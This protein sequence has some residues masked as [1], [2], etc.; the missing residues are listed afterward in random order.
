MSKEPRQIPSAQWIESAVAA[1]WQVLLDSDP[2]QPLREELAASGVAPSTVASLYPIRFED[3]IEG[4]KPLLTAEGLQDLSRL[5][6]VISLDRRAGELFKIMPPS[7]LAVLDEELESDSFFAEK[8]VALGDYVLKLLPAALKQ[9][10]DLM[11]RA[12]VTKLWY[13]T[14]ML[15][16]RSEFEDDEQVLHFF[17]AV[18]ERLTPN[19]L[20]EW[21]IGAAY[22]VEGAH[23]R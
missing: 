8:I 17:M 12:I 4:W 10:S 22:A 18:T 20:P 11:A 6:T 23:E 3:L 16:H 21:S 19:F 9:N 14:T 15:A 7:V 5:D 2:N 1:R 13:V